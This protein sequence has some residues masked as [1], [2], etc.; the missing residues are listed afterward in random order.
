[1]LLA[2]ASDVHLDH[3]SNA[4][5]DGFMDE[6]RENAPDALVLSG[7]ISNASHLYRHLGMFE[8]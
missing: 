8:T 4:A 5:I 1:M 7:D 6:I 3:C 2:W